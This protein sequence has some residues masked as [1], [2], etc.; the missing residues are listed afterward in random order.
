MIVRKSWNAGAWTP[1]D[2]TPFRG[3]LP[4]STKP[5]T[6]RLSGGD[7][8]MRPAI[9]FALL[10]LAAASQASADSLALPDGYWNPQ[11]SQPILDKTGPVRLAP[12]LTAL[13]QSE[14]DA[15]RSL[16][17]VGEIMQEI[18]ETSRHAEARRA[19]SELNA[20]HEELG[21]PLATRNLL[22]L[23]RLNQGPIAVTLDNRREAFVPVAPQVPGRN[24]YPADV[25]REE[26]DAYLAAH[27]A[28]RD[29]ILGERTVVRRATAANL[30]ADLTTLAMYALIRELAPREADRLRKLRTR[31]DPKAF[32]AV[33]YS[34]AYAPQLTRA[35]GGLL[36]AA[37]AMDATD[38]EFAR[39]LRNRARDLV[40][41]DYEA[42]DA[43]WVRGRFKRLNAQVGAYETYDDAL[44]GVKAFHAASL[45][46]RNE[47]ASSELRSALSGLQSIENALPYDAH[48]RVND[49]IPIGVYEVIADFGQARGVNTATILPNDALFSRRYGRTILMR[50]NILKNPDLFAT[51]QRVWRAAVTVDHADD[52]TPLGIFQRTLWHEIGHYL[53]PERDERGRTL[54][55]ALENYADA[56]EEMKSDL[57]SQ[58]ALHR[59]RP[60]ALRD[61]QASGILRTLLNVKPRSDQPYQ[62]MQ[63]AQFNWF[64]DR[65]LI[66]ADAQARLEI[67]YA[68]YPDTVKSLLAEV[69]RLQLAGDK[70]QVAAFFERWTRWQPELH[71]R[72]AT[73]IRDAQGIRFRMVHYGALG[74]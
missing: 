19:Y 67:D 36:D 45:L 26:L 4:G 50:E 42:G 58:F 29:S 8:E 13:T 68:R 71:E 66:R 47:S 17:A 27:P 44:Y 51:S 43:S 11:Q 31:P 56:L 55:V 22:D 69:L 20:L 14:R 37:D 74:E 54:D 21:R 24:V 48:K 15:L 23:Y 35:Y 62:T 60:T 73:R 49:D 25:T 59:M 38:A 12:D 52:L 6:R 53:G 33:P 7:L 5:E 18:Y 16:I 1:G 63:L 3:N 10:T 61:I 57:V 39:Y 2:P 40:S 9:C 34:I 32:Y 30:D 41:N 70:A 64:L 72:L 28:E 46:L 65:G